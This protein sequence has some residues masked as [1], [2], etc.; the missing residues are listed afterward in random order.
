[1]AGCNPQDEVL[2]ERSCRE[3]RASATAMQR[4]GG[5]PVAPTPGGIVAGRSVRVLEADRR[6]RLLPAVVRR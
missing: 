4:R 6:G 5:R 1:M 3:S 2:A